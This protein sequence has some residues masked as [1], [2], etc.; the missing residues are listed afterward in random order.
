MARLLL[1]ALVCCAVLG[2]QP[3]A[4][5]EAKQA[6][7]DVYRLVFFGPVRPVLIGLQIRVDGEEIGSSRQRYMDSLFASLDQDGDGRLDPAEAARIPTA[8]QLGT[9]STG[10]RFDWKELDRDGDEAVSR[11]ELFVY[12]LRELGPPLEMIER[13]LRPVQVIDF[14]GLLDQD[15]DGRISE[16]ERL[17]IYEAVKKLD[18]DRDETWN[19]DELTSFRNPDSLNAAMVQRDPTEIPFRMLM[20]ETSAAEV[21]AEIQKRYALAHGG[22]GRGVGPVQL[23]RRPSQLGSFDGDGDGRLSV[24]EL[25]AFLQQGTPEVRLIAELPNRKAGL[26]ALAAVMNP[27]PNSNESPPGRRQLDVEMGGIGLEMRA[28]RPPTT[29]YDSRQ[30]YRL[31]FRIADADKNKYLDRQEFSA[32]NL[33]G[34]TFDALDRD[35]DGT[36]VE[37]EVTD[38]IDGRSGAAENRVVMTISREGQSLFEALDTDR[39]RRLSTRELRAAPDR[40]AALDLDRNGVLV[41]TEL[42]GNYR[43]TFEISR[44]GLLNSPPPMAMTGPASAPAPRGSTSGPAWFQKMDLNRDGEVSEREFLGPLDLFQELDADGDGFLSPEEAESA[45]EE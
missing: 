34:A 7:P 19:I 3:A 25:T 43:L 2:A 27:D 18:L 8:D 22:D 31:Q 4:G 33:P 26:P 23:G 28:G 12:V 45:E 24:T 41:E 20:D 35:G 30:F 32:L 11:E 6:Q 29:T 36:V 39:D 40:L 10:E 21:A 16:A 38:Y 44:G 17:S 14:F 5:S 37:K 15:G 13:P 1:H 9:D 42:V